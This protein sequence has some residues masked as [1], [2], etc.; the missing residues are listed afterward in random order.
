[1]SQEEIDYWKM[2]QIM[3][4]SFKSQIDNTPG[5]SPIRR[6]TIHD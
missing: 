5:F 6:K 2:Y 1:M 4:N 3:N